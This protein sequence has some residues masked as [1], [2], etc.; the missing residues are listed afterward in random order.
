MKNTPYAK[1]AIKLAVCY[2]IIGGVC[3]S[4][5]AQSE[6]RFRRVRDTPIGVP[7]MA[8]N[9]GPSDVILDTGAD[10]T[11]V[12]TPPSIT[13]RTHVFVQ[14]PPEKLRRAEEVASSI[15]HRAGVDVVWINCDY[16]IPPENREPGC[17]QPLGPLDLVLNIVDRIQALSPKMSEIA[18]G[19]AAVPSGGGQGDSAYL[20]MRQAETVACMS[21]VPLETVLGLGAAHE[22]GHLLLGENAHSATGLMKAKWGNDELKLGSNGNLIFLLEQ[23]S[24]IRA[25]LLARKKKASIS[26]IGSPGALKSPLR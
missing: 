14:V 7:L 8:G 20:G 25:N 23:A 12:D 2:F 3:Q 9:D 22:M 24:R 11:I 21:S 5:Q 18:M 1:L 15:L 4:I 13:A 10:T 16:T 19:V 6:I 26:T 17:A